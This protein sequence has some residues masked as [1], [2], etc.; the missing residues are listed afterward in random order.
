MKNTALWEMTLLYTDTGTLI[1]ASHSRRYLPSDA[2]LCGPRRIQFWS[3]FVQY[4]DHNNKRNK[5]FK[6]NFYAAER[7]ITQNVVFMNSIH[8]VSEVFGIT[9]H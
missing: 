7:Y 6:N 2:L 3:A 9:I 4:S 1:M 8:S 5:F